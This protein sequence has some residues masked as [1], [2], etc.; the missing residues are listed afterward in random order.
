MIMKRLPQL[1]I[2]QDLNAISKTDCQQSRET[3]LCFPYICITMQGMQ[4]TR[5]KE[6]QS[7][8]NFNKSC[9]YNKSKLNALLAALLSSCVSI[10]HTG[11]RRPV[12]GS[13]ASASSSSNSSSTFSS[14]AACGL[15][16]DLMTCRNMRKSTAQM[17]HR[18][19]QT[20]TCSASRNYVEVDNE[21][22]RELKIKLKNR[23]RRQFNALSYKIPIYSN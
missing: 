3:N 11:K 9:K 12:N 20:A 22:K 16:P 15:W 18:R 14:A 21:K 7:I 1:N 23:I 8:S 13:S 2:Q 17:W 5:Q 19:L 6:Q 4:R 10:C